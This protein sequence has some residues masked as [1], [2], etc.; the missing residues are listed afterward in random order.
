MLISQLPETHS[1]GS[2]DSGSCQ[3][4]GS[5]EDGKCSVGTREE[6]ISW[7]FLN[8]IQGPGESPPIPSFRHTKTASVFFFFFN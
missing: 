1:P 4:A 5:G 2:G 3:T 6:R 8:G 7:W